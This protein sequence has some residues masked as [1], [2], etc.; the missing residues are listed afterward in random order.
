M[1]RRAAR[2]RHPRRHWPIPAAFHD[3]TIYNLPRKTSSSLTLYRFSYSPHYFNF[4]FFLNLT[5]DVLTLI[6]FIAA[7]QRLR[8]RLPR[9]HHTLTACDHFHYALRHFMLTVPVNPFTVIETH[10]VDDA[11]N[12]SLIIVDVAVFFL[13]NCFWFV[14]FYCKELGEL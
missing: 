1:R 3:I 11:C 8:S 2:G 13:Y 9:V 4:L 10:L 7:R 12:L 14:Y 5:V 6:F